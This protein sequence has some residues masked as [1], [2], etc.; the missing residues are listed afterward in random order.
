VVDAANGTK[1]LDGRPRVVQGKT[2]IGAYQQQPPVISPVTL[3]APTAG[4]H[5]SRA[6]TAAGGSAPYTFSVASGALPAG[7]SLSSGGVLS[8]TPTTAGTNT[9]T[10][11]ATDAH[12]FVGT[13]Q[14]TLRVLPGLSGPSAVARK[15]K[16]TLT[17]TAGPGQNVKLFFTRLGQSRGLVT[18]T[19]ADAST[20]HFTFTPVIT[21]TGRFD[22]TA[23][24]QRSKSH[25]IATNPTLSAPAH[26]Q[27]G[28]QVTLKGE[29]GP[30]SKVTLYRG[31]PGHPLTRL[32]A[33]RASSTGQ[34]VFTITLQSPVT[35]FQTSAS[36]LRSKTVTVRSP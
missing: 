21:A 28:H 29:V 6:L 8:G 22:V 10:I 26:V 36:G 20:G 18:H 32:A 30:R 1:D 11:H 33:K 14:Y 4:V 34:Y 27:P 25:L 31:T 15:H 24:G 13:R 5:Y 23:N 2:D 9:A 35:T 16:A 7:L 3:P 19:T 12:G 17:G